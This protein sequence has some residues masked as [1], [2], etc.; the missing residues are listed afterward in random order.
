MTFRID[1]FSQKLSGGVFQSRIKECEFFP[2]LL[3]KLK[4][5][6]YLKRLSDHLI[7]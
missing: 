7:F 4:H 6:V 3:F 2:P 1:F 5:T